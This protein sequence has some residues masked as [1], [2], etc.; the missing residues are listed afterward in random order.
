MS[1][2]DFSG[3]L[4]Q[5]NRISRCFSL[6]NLIQRRN[7]LHRPSLRLN[8]TPAIP[9]PTWSGHNYHGSRI[10]SSWTVRKRKGHH[11]PSLSA[12][13]TAESLVVAS[14]NKSKHTSAGNF[15]SPL[16][17]AASSGGRGDSR[18]SG[19]TASTEDIFH[20]QNSSFNEL[21]NES[22]SGSPLQN[23]SFSP[24]EAPTSPII[25]EET[26]VKRSNS[27]FSQ[28]HYRGGS[29]AGLTSPEPISRNPISVATIYQ[30]TRYH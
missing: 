19:L 4:S 3:L 2:F 26:K 1:E 18:S 20:C 7:S 12:M 8:A 11:R 29:Q 21:L 13:L 10:Y 5:M 24:S 15:T 17:D 14:H 23:P 25:D 30:P 6:K 9:I 28:T 16:E 22:A 27:G